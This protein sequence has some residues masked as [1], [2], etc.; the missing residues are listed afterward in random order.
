MAGLGRRTHYRKHLTDSV[1]NDLP[2]PTNSNQ[3]IAKVTGT[4]GSNQ[5][6]LVVAPSTTTTIRYDDDAKIMLPEL[7]MTAQL[8][9]LP[10]KYRK[11]IWLKRNDYVICECA[12]GNDNH[13]VDSKEENDDDN[14]DDNDDASKTIS[15]KNTNTIEG[16]IRFMITHILYKDQIKHLKEKNLWPM[17]SFF[18]NSA[19]GNIH[20]STRQGGNFI[21]D[22]KMKTEDEILIEKAKEL[23][24]KNKNHRDHKEEE[25]DHNDSN[26]DGE[27]LDE[28]E[29]YDGEAY[30]YTDDGINFSNDNDYFVNTN[31]IAKMKIEDSSSD[32]DSD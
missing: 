31:R 28:E 26:H 8:S 32:E 30:G 4:R 18:S 6:E 23:M 3:R 14:H 7:D 21:D 24:E 11:L 1:W 25:D 22:Q 2:E 10:T 12:E 15:G 29:E 17:H 19:T 9:I 13:D 27:I 20:D 5:F 16:G